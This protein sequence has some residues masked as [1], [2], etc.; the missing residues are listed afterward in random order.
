VACA[1]R[2]DVDPATADI[3]CG[4]RR[5]TGACCKACGGTE[6]AAGAT[7]PEPAKTAAGTTV[8]ARRLANCWFTAGCGGSAPR[9]V[10]AIVVISVIV[11]A[12]TLAMLTLPI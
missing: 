8:A 6:S 7:L 4:G 9:C 3:A 12:L 1:G 10:R 5:L 2:G 11:V